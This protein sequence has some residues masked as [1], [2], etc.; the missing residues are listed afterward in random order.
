MKHLMFV[1]R[2]TCNVGDCHRAHGCHARGL[3]HEPVR[4]ATAN[5]RCGRTGE[6]LEEL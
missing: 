1:I 6:K 3:V 2:T 4:P 5:R